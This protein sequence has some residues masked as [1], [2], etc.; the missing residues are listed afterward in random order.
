MKS[1]I[2]GIFISGILTLGLGIPGIFFFALPLAKN[3]HEI[4]Q[5]QSY[6]AVPAKVIQAEL[7][8]GKEGARTI[9]TRYG[10]TFKGESYESIRIGL[11]D[12]G[13]DNLGTWHDE[14]IVRLRA[15]LLNDSPITAWVNPEQPQQV[16]LDR[17]IR[18]PRLFFEL[19]FAILFPVL[20][21]FALRIFIKLLKMPLTT[22]ENGSLKEA[23]THAS[24]IQKSSA[25]PGLGI[26]IFALFWNLL[27]WSFAGFVWCN[28][29]GYG[30]L[31]IVLIFLISGLYILWSAITSR[32]NIISVQGPDWWIFPQQ[33]QVGE[34]FSVV[35][36]LPPIG[37][38]FFELHLEEGCR[39]VD[40]DSPGVRVVW[41]DQQYLEL[42]QLA[43]GNGKI[44]AKFSIPADRNPTSE[45][46]KS[47]KE[48]VWSLRL[49]D[50]ENDFIESRRITVL[51]GNVKLN[52][53]G[54]NLLS[55]TVRQESQES[56]SWTA[57][58][59]KSSFVPAH[60][61]N[62]SEESGRW[63]AQFPIT[64]A[65]WFGIFWLI[66]TTGLFLWARKNYL[67]NESI[68]VA[69]SIFW[70]CAACGA[71]WVG[72]SQFG[73]TWKLIVDQSGLTVIRVNFLYSRQ[74][75]LAR[76][77]VTG[78]QKKLFVRT[79]DIDGGRSYYRIYAL[80]RIG[81][82]IQITPD[83]LW[84]SVANG[85][86]HYIRAALFDSLKFRSSMQVVP[87]QFNTS[88][89]F[90]WLLYLGIAFAGITATSLNPTFLPG[91][92]ISLKRILKDWEA[93]L[94]RLGPSGGQY[95]EFAI[96]Q[97][98]GDLPAIEALLKN[99]A[100]PNAVANNGATYLMV[101]AHNGNLEYLNL[102]L[103]Y[104]ADVNQRDE[105]S[106]DNRGDTALLVALHS[107]QEKIVLR[108]L[109]AGASLDVVNMWDWTPM[110]MAAQSFCVPCLELLLQKGQSIHAKAYASR[111]ETPV[112]LAAGKGRI[113]ALEWLVKHGADLEEK[114]P[115]GNNALDWAIFFHQENT[116]RWIR[117]Y[118]DKNP[119]KESRG[120]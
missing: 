70:V 9:H 94:D 97:D 105:T 36:K 23:I 37:N 104:G 79:S 43:D 119:K 18:W 41:F 112:M 60:V 51:A 21:L 75:N 114:D 5:A 4:W 33:P 115:F 27:A 84:F 107:G 59:D 92:P 56:D 118:L 53:M 1:R 30:Y 80:T 50:L 64:Y 25:R 44:S 101:A 65:R 40:D 88:R 39:Y 55:V 90:S 91:D 102:L 26:W 96:A 42:Q 71:L 85:V 83:I 32:K 66:V 29:S 116:E 15:S 113:E 95:A 99:G 48:T 52:E 82:C 10:Y 28:Y 117:K 6:E 3:L 24:V 87:D 63:I 47:G 19:P 34:T 12:Q 74:L 106:N 16:L 100:N 14:W 31:L 103:R 46:N 111:G 13:S 57:A 49:I 68:D 108:L 76:E 77:E 89:V 8:Y 120:Q 22:D 110:H 20:S 109:E 78:F 73:K 17:N 35:I 11:F 72:L 7:V 58:G 98:R 62:I 38:Q 61:V 2:V 67:K 93:R 54:S 45:K 81:R 86:A 69:W